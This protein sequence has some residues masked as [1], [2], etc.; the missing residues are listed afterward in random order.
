MEPSVSEDHTVLYEPKGQ[1]DDTVPTDTGTSKS[2]FEWP[3][4]SFQTYRWKSDP[5]IKGL[6]SRREWNEIQGPY[7][8]AVVPAIAEIS[9]VLVPAETEVAANEASNEIARF[10]GELGKEISSFAAILLR[11]ESA[12]SSKIEKLTS[13]ARAIA[14]AELGDKSRRNAS[15]IVS[16]SKAM[17]SAIALANDLSEESIIAMH[18]ALLGESDPEICGHWRDDQVWIGG[19]DFSPKGADFVPPHQDLVPQSMADLIAFLR[20]DD[21]PSF[22]QAAVAHA[23]FETIHPFPDG[24]GRV[25]RALIHALMRNKGITR[26]ITVPVSAGLLVNIERYFAALNAYHD[27]EPALIV[28]RLAE[29]TFTAIGNGRMLIDDLHEI[30]SEWQDVIAARSDSAAWRLA[31]LMLRQPIIDSSLVQREVHISERNAFRAIE[32]L[33]EVG[34]LRELTN[35]GR[36]RRWE[37]PRVIAALESFAERSGRRRRAG[38]STPA[39]QPQEKTE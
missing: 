9:R 31:D 34:V 23:Q 25:G 35:R 8:A 36:D 5:S 38:K 16:N 17:Q 37:A 21:I 33:V 1:Y 13:S 28:A 15:L 32:R 7:Q 26:S 4:I 39:D 19:S 10:D 29:A 3:K 24:N 30:R 6:V 20:R 11:T 18:E 22:I 12:A 2:D 27:G 14:L